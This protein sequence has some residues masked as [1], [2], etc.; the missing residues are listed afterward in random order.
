MVQAWKFEKF[1]S[2]AAGIGR[3]SE[4]GKRNLGSG[5]P[6]LARSLQ[7]RILRHL[8]RGQRRNA[9]ARSILLTRHRCTRA[10]RYRSIRRTSNGIMFGQCLGNRSPTLHELGDA[11]AIAFTPFSS[12]V[13]CGNA[14]AARSQGT[15]QPRVLPG[16]VL[17]QRNC[18]FTAPE[19]ELNIARD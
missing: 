10:T 9:P 16:T 7:P 19:R 4:S 8:L 5:Y 17:L 14:F 15:S 12:R 2:F 11:S 6:A 1:A 3:N 13:S 18:A